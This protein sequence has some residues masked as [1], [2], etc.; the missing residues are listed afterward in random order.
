M[1]LVYATDIAL[2]FKFN[3]S[4]T[5]GGLKARTKRHLL[6]LKA[7]IVHAMRQIGD[8]IEAQVE[9]IKAKNF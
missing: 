2:F 8:P 6:S 4:N 1:K 9:V 5:L 7:P 3:V